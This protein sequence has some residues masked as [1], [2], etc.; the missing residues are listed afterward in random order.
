MRLSD[1]TRSLAAPALLGGA[2]WAAVA[3][4][5]MIATFADIIIGVSMVADSPAWNAI[6]Y[7]VRILGPIGILISVSRLRGRSASV[8]EIVAGRAGP[9]TGAELERALRRV[10]N[11]PSLALAYAAADAW[12]GTDGRQLDL[13]NIP[14]GRVATVVPIAGSPSVGI[15]HDVLLLEEPAL[16]RTLTAV[17][18]L[19]VDNERLQSDLRAQLVE[20]KASRARIAEAADAERRRV[21]RDLHDGAQQRLVALLVSLRTIRS[22]LGATPDPAVTSELDAASIEVRAAIAEVRELAQGLDPAIVREAGLAAAIRSLAD[23]SPVPVTLDVTLDERLPARIESTAYFVLS[24]ALANVAKHSAAT[25][26]VVRAHETDNVLY[27]TV[28]DDGTGAADP[29]GH[30]LRGLADRVAAADARMTLSSPRGEGTTIEV[31]IP[32]AS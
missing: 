13:D 19:A 8:I 31:A 23:R 32:C 9:P 25:R 22:R 11:D 5:S 7:S 15:I 4:F 30:G 24:E 2:A 14:S 12:V 17:V 6:Q 28:A 27:L 26:V 10:F 18:G 1:A 29:N 20:V 21:E 16:R 3:A